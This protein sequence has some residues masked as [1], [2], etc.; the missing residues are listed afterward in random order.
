MSSTKGFTGSDNKQ[1]LRPGLE[2]F[3]RLERIAKDSV[4]VSMGRILL[5]ASVVPKSKVIL[6]A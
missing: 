4:I 6:A 5:L 1:K 2:D 3:P